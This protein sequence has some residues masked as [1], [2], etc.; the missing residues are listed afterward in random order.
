MSGIIVSFVLVMLCW[1]KACTLIGCSKSHDYL[2]LTNQS[3]LWNHS[4]AMLKICIGSRLSLLKH[5]KRNSFKFRADTFLTLQY[6]WSY[7][8][9]FLCL[10]CCQWPN[11]D[12]F[13]KLSG[14]TLLQTRNVSMVTTGSDSFYEALCRDVIAPKFSPLFYPE[15]LQQ[16]F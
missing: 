13:A 16:I 14:H 4:V 8:G 10:V 5:L 7:L 9:T 11:F 15:A 6:F 2:F 3:T 1:I 12:K